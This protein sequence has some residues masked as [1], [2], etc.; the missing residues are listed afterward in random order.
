M[1]SQVWMISRH[2]SCLLIQ[3]HIM[4]RAGRTRELKRIHFWI[5]YIIPCP[6]VLQQQ[7][8]RIFLQ[9]DGREQGQEGIAELE[10]S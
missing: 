5:L 2:R 1:I 10:G 9:K 6:E 3:W 7:V 8:F 4:H